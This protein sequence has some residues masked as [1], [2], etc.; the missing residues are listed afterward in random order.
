MNVSG[1][2]ESSKYNYCSSGSVALSLEHKEKKKYQ[3]KNRKCTRNVK[4][5][6]KSQGIA[7]LLRSKMNAAL[8]FSSCKRGPS[9][10][11]VFHDGHL[12]SC[13]AAHRPMAH[14]ANHAHLGT[15]C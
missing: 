1:S 11:G 4:G 6:D 7:R 3:A 10:R 15:S 9:G 8:L 12:P 5:N 14:R 13:G 2:I